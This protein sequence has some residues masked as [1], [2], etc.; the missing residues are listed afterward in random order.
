MALN[1]AY[2]SFQVDL[3]SLTQGH[4]ITVG[5]PQ[6]LIAWENKIGKEIVHHWRTQLKESVEQNHWF[7]L[8]NGLFKLH[9]KFSH[10][11]KL[12][13][14]W[15]MINAGWIVQ[16]NKSRLNPYKSIHIHFV[17]QQKQAL[18]ISYVQLW[19]LKSF[20]LS[21]SW[22]KEG[23]HLVLTLFLWSPQEVN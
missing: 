12:S 4:Q 10:I 3:C 21:K 7:D 20:T 13:Q 17:S 2:C 5:C 11:L 15:F 18:F 9:I 6:H 14:N 8:L 19:L 23:T 16:N 1:Q 22:F